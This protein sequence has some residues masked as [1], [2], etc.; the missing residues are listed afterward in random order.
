MPTSPENKN[1]AVLKLGLAIKK[2]R[3]SQWHW[4]GNNE[5]KDDQDRLNSTGLLR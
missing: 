1:G 4:V 3:Q 5:K 2:D